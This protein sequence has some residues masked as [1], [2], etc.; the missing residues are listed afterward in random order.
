MAVE[1]VG[2]KVRSQWRNQMEQEKKLK[3]FAKETALQMTLAE[4]MKTTMLEELKGP[5]G[6][7]MIKRLTEALTFQILQAIERELRAMA[8]DS[9]GQMDIEQALARLQLRKQ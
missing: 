5:S 1:D 3:P 6:Q 7:A 4:Y 9:G 2:I 8:A